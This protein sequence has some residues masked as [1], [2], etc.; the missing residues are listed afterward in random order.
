M[1]RTLNHISGTRVTLRKNQPFQFALQ[2]ALQIYKSNSIFT[3]IPKNACST[4]RY[5]IARANDFIDSEADFHW[6]HMNN[7][8][9][10]PHLSSLITAD[11]TSVILRCPFSRLASAFLDKF[12]KQTPDAERYYSHLGNKMDPL[13]LTFRQFVDSLNKPFLLNDNIHW[14]PQ[15]DFLIYR[16]YDD[17]LAIEDFKNASETL[18]DKIN[19]KVFDARKLT[20]HGIDGLTLVHED[21]YNCH[22]PLSELIKL[23]KQNRMISPKNLFDK[24]TYSRVENIFSAD[25]NLYIDKFGTENLMK[26]K[27]N[28]Y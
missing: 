17:Y 15:S 11:Y 7:S 16:N 28:S 4:M 5:S 3:F 13:D 6:I 20:N 25:I 12:I 9:F 23:R 18:E 10:N 26:I 27:E 8:T 1:N 24:E 21:H 19:L 22:T 2:Y 14:R